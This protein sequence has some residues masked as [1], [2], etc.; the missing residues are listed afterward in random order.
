MRVQE[1][2]VCGTQEKRLEKE[3]GHILKSLVKEFRLYHKE[4]QEVGRVYA[5]A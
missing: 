1:A 3:T 4:Y 2:G 5:G